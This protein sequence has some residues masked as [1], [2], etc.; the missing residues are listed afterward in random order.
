MEALSYQHYSMSFDVRL[1]LQIYCY[2]THFSA[3]PTPVLTSHLFFA[4][5]VYVSQNKQQHFSYTPLNNWFL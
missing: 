3:I 2:F 4:T 5:C 1:Y